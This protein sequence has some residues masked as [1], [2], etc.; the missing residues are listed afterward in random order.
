MTNPPRLALS[1]SLHARLLRCPLSIFPSPL[2]VFARTPF[3][4]LLLLL[5]NNLLLISLKQYRRSI[6]IAQRY[7]ILRWARSNSRTPLLFKKKLSTLNTTLS[8]STT[9]TTTNMKFSTAFVLLSGAP[10]AL[11][12]Q[13]VGKTFYNFVYMYNLCI[14]II[15]C[16]YSMCVGG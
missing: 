13:S 7:L 12:F 4:A 9:T 2:S 10:A 16:V 15:L 11:G 8:R 6:I 1:L 14:C 5:C 3:N